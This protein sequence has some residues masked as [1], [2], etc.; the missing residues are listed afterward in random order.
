MNFY[1]AFINFFYKAFIKKF[2]QNFCNQTF[3]NILFPI[4]SSNSRENIIGILLTSKKRRQA[5][6][7]LVDAW[8]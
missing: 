2:I 8:R 6:F 4:S 3:S 5:K 1:E 7:W